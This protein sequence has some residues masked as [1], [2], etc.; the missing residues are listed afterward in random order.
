M[1]ELQALFV[2]I[3]TQFSTD[4]YM[5]TSRLQGVL[6]SAADIVLVLFFLKIA[7]L[8]R[9]K[10]LKRRMVFRYLFLWI[11]ALLTPL[12]FFAPT[13]KSFFGLETVIC[14]MQFLILG[15]TIIL[16]RK[17]MMEMLQSFA[18]GK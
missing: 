6:W 1:N 9:R 16:E 17:V 3:S 18:A 13:P 7:D 10:A 2:W 14:G 11:S 4:L 12:L 15:Y 8:A 5:M